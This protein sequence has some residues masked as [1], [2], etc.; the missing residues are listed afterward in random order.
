MLNVCLNAVNEVE[1]SSLV[2]EMSCSDRTNFPSNLIKGLFWVYTDASEGHGGGSFFWDSILINLK[3]VNVTELNLNPQHLIF[4]EVQNSQCWARLGA[5]LCHL[6]LREC[7]Y[8]GSD[9]S[10]KSVGGRE[11]YFYL[12]K[13]SRSSIEDAGLLGAVW[14]CWWYPF[15]S[16]AQPVSPSTTGGRIWLS[17][18]TVGNLPY[19]LGGSTLCVLLLSV[20]EV[21]GK[22]CLYLELLGLLPYTLNP[23]AYVY[24]NVIGQIKFIE[25][26]NEQSI[27]AVVSLGFGEV[28]HYFSIAD[29]KLLIHSEIL[30]LG[31]RVKSWFVSGV[32]RCNHHLSR[33]KMQADRK[34]KIS[35]VTSAEL[36]EFI[37][38]AVLGIQEFLCSRLLVP[39]ARWDFFLGRRRAIKIVLG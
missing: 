17:P 35:R 26:W 14:A 8:I 13:L 7:L 15:L 9:E 24:F 39:S 1:K 28:H 34:T 6:I 29:L 21:C 18:L 27:S 31:I 32:S 5:K 2:S 36:E 16:R 30:L 33:C 11:R 4:Q 10:L 12:Q 20:W 25:T 3:N 22:E 23:W 19:D 38:G 37:H